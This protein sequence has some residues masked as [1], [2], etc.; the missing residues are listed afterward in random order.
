MTNV[1]ALFDGMRRSIVTRLLFWLLCASL[2]YALIAQTVSYRQDG[3]QQTIQLNRTLLDS[4]LD[5]LELFLRRVADPA[6]NSRLSK[7]NNHQFFSE[8]PP[9]IVAAGLQ[10]R[11]DTGNRD[12]FEDRQSY[13]SRSTF[14]IREYRDQ[15]SETWADSSAWF[16]AA[17][18]SQYIPLAALY[19]NQ[20]S[21]PLNYLAGLDLMSDRFFGAAIRAAISGGE[22]RQSKPFRYRD[23][24]PGLAFVKAIYQ[25][26]ITPGTTE[27]RI[28]RANGVAVVF[29]DMDKLFNIPENNGM[30][31]LIEREGEV[32]LPATTEDRLQLS[33]IPALLAG[34]QQT[35][36]PARHSLPYRISLL[37]PGFSWDWLMLVATLILLFVIALYHRVFLRPSGPTGQNIPFQIVEQA[38]YLERQALQ[39]MDDAVLVIS[40]RRQI[41]YANPCA[42]ILTSDPVLQGKLL[43][44]VDFGIFHF[45]NERRVHILP[46]LMER[47]AKAPFP[48]DSFLVDS[49][50]TACEIEGEFTPLSDSTSS[51]GHYLITFRHVGP[52]RQSMSAALKA[53]EAQLKK[54][55]DELARIARINTLGEMSSGVAHEIN[56]PLSAIMSYNEACLAMMDDANPDPVLLRI[57]LVSSVKQANRAGQIIRRLRELASRKQP[58]VA[59]LQINDALLSALDLTKSE[60]NTRDVIVTTDLAQDLPYILADSIQ[61]EQV[62]IN[63]I[64]NAVDA[65]TDKAAPSEV[66]RIFAYTERRGRHVRLG[67]RDNGTGIPENILPHVFDPFYSSKSEGMGLG[68][69]IS[70]SIV[71]SIGGKLAARNLETGGAEFSVTLPAVK[72]G[73]ADEKEEQ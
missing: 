70:Q 72:G 20:P 26:E 33:S 19:P 69:T 18:R 22:V 27:E 64:K 38:N 3:F 54:H 9:F 50:G 1:R 46:R 47:K 67:I 23:G 4:Q 55:Q 25:D 5:Y 36:Q 14:L 61:L 10:V 62:I 7:T 34:Q 32:S 28:A 16:P 40:I 29:I 43:D 48:D 41:I 56:Q 45:R 37:Q 42:C 63:L 68:L 13:Q 52:M 24:R 66:M 60:L 15:N 59:P 12:A 73:N 44:A 53:C 2:G 58:V 51:T 8:H 31:L 49:H 57:S 65:M 17:A 21:N 71:E 39:A 6:S 30:Q 11:V 35:L